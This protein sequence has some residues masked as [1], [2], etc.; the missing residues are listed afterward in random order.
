M[1]INRLGQG[2]ARAVHVRFT[3]DEISFEFVAINY[4]AQFIFVTDGQTDGDLCRSNGL[5]IAIASS[6]TQ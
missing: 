3:L 2:Q 4:L 5:H 6:N 1:T